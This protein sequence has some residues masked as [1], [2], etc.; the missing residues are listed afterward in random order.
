M[1][2]KQE[3]MVKDEY[4]ATDII[5]QVAKI[6]EIMKRVMKKGEHFDIIPGTSKPSL[7]KPGAEK[8]GLT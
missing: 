5:H 3:I 1:E 2:S 4:D 7:L 6:Q 8:L